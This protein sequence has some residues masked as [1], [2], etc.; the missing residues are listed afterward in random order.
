MQKKLAAPLTSSF[1]GLSL[2]PHFEIVALDEVRFSIDVSQEGRMLD[3]V[4]VAE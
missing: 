1:N 2:N 3:P 4:G